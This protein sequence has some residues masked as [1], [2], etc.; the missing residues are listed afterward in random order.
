M[1]TAK[2]NNAIDK[3]IATPYDPLKDIS[4][5]YTLAPDAQKDNNEKLLSFVSDY[6]DLIKDY[7]AGKSQIY[8]VYSEKYNTN[9]AIISFNTLNSYT[10]EMKILLNTEYS[11]IK[12]LS[13]LLKETLQKL[14]PDTSLIII[15]LTSHTE[16]L[17]YI[18]RKSGFRRL[19][20]SNNC[21][22][23]YFLTS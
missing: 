1:L 5:Y 21:L 22:V 18:I 16:I 4:E 12:H 9:I 23:Y 20:R 14:S 10:A 13:E 15:K 2:L 6:S 7:N 8:T 3:L 19:A 17:A 11:D